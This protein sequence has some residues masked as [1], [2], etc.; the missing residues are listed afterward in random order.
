[1]YEV[2]SLQ[3]QKAEFTEFEHVVTMATTN[4]ESV[5]IQYT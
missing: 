2:T 1:M 5:H 3:T 4:E